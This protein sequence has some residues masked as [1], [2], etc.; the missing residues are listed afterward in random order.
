MDKQR[1]KD[2][3]DRT[4]GECGCWRTGWK[5]LKEDEGECRIT[6]ESTEDNYK[7]P[8]VVRNHYACPNFALRMGVK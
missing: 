4:C 6:W 1:N 2:Y 3:Q 8:I 5:H 7:C